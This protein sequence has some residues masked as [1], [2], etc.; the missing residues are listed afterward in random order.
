LFSDLGS[1][2]TDFTGLRE[3]SVKFSL[4]KREREREKGRERKMERLVNVFEL[5][6]LKNSS[7][8]KRIH[9]N[10]LVI[11]KQNKL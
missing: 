11:Q 9:E 8:K 6:G 4:L 7:N 10:I 1:L 2:V 3:G 5:L